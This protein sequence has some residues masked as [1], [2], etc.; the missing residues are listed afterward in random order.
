MPTTKRG[1]RHARIGRAAIV[2]GSKRHWLLL[3]G[4]ELFPTGEPGFDDDAQM[5]E[6]WHV[7]RDDLM[8]AC[9]PGS[10]PYAWWRFDAKV[11]SARLPVDSAAELIALLDR[12]AIAPDEAVRIEANNP[13]MQPGCQIWGSNLPGGL[14]TDDPAILQAIARSFEAIARWHAWRGRPELA[15]IYRERADRCAAV[16]EAMPLKL[17]RYEIPTPRKARRETR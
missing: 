13:A 3:H 2:E 11:S 8:R 17:P 9:E 12:G 16:I 15:D 14:Q 1:L 5:Q 4:H 6:A 10:R 7:H